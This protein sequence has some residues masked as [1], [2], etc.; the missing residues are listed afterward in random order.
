MIKSNLT[1]KYIWNKKEIG[2]A[3]DDFKDFKYMKQTI[4]FS[5]VYMSLFLSYRR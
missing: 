2:Q 3:W 1:R 4:Y 5:K